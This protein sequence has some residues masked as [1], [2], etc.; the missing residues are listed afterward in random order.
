M[1]TAYKQMLLN[2]GE[3]LC[4]SANSGNAWEQVSKCS[5]Q[6]WDRA[7]DYVGCNVYSSSDL[8]YGAKIW[9][10]GPRYSML[11]WT[12]IASGEKQ[13]LCGWVWL[14]PLLPRLIL[15][16]HGTDRSDV[17]SAVDYWKHEVF[18]FLNHMYPKYTNVSNVVDLLC[19]SKKVVKMTIIT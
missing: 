16:M 8:L 3:F 2:F 10:L 17:E 1:P 12:P 5:S 4:A 14:T 9:S 7:Q 18:L 13:Q 19:S 15:P 6:G 11:G